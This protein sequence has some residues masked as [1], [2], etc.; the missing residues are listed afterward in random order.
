MANLSFVVQFLRLAAKH[1]SYNSNTNSHFILFCAYVILLFFTAHNVMKSCQW[2]KCTLKA[3]EINRLEI[4]C[5]VQ[6][7]LN[8]QKS[9]LEELQNMVGTVSIVSVFHVVD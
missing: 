7:N 1:L 3:H 5:L 6:D 9:M 8:K 4:T 2:E